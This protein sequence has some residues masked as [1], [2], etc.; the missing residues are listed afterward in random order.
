MGVVAKAEIAPDVARYNAHRALR[1]PEYAGRVV[2]VANDA[3][4]RAGVDRVEAG[5]WVRGV[6]FARWSP[7]APS[8]RK[9]EIADWLYT[10]EHRFVV[11]SAAMGVLRNPKLGDFS[12]LTDEAIERRLV[13]KLMRRGMTEDQALEFLRRGRCRRDRSSDSPANAA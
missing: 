6:T 11:Y 4:P 8:Y 3:A 9:G 5:R 13:E 12:G 10:K 1:K 7:S 2:A